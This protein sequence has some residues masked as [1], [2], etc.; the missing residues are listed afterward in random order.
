[1][2]INYY[3]KHK[4]KLRIEACERY[5]NL[6]DEEKEKRR[7]KVWERYQNLPEE[8]KEK[9]RQYHRE[10]HKNLSEKLKQKQVEYLKGIKFRGSLISRLEKNY[11]LRVI[12]VAIW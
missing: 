12:N 6:S 5:Q 7:K 8:K 4:E 2:A 10:R 3:Q 11:I 1:M 9:K